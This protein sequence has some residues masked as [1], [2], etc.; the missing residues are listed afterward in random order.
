M[1]MYDNVRDAVSVMN[2]RVGS[3]ISPEIMMEWPLPFPFSLG[4]LYWYRSWYSGEFIKNMIDKEFDDEAMKRLFSCNRDVIISFYSFSRGKCR[5]SKNQLRDDATIKNKAS[6]FKSV[7][8]AAI[9]ATGIFPPVYV[10]G[11][12]MCTDAGYCEYVP[13]IDV[14]E[15]FKDPPKSIDVYLS[16]PNHYGPRKNETPSILSILFN[17]VP[18]Y[19][20]ISH[21]NKHNTMIFIT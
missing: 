2:K 17:I 5:L 15:F 3:Y 14:C 9:S 16:V 12:G 13:T 1:A 21:R 6:L 8:L 11:Y 18:F 4:Y 7:L 10:E 19:L 20:G